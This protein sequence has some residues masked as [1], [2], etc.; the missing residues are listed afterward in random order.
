MSNRRAIA[1]IFL[2]GVVI[3]LV[4]ILLVSLI[5][6]LI[7]RNTTNSNNKTATAVVAKK[8][9][10]IGEIAANP[11]LF[12]DK[13]VIIDGSIISWATPHAFVIS[14][15]G[16]SILVITKQSYP[17]P[18]ETSGNNVLT[19]G[20]SAVVSVEGK[21]ER[22]DLAELENKWGVNLDDKVLYN[23]NNSLVIEADSI[24]QN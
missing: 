5:R 1:L 8:N 22:L 4:L 13:K 15:D 2:A 12:V 19:V 20:S 23:W 7:S 24:K 16:G 10:T 17:L 18:T 14:G 9:I 6:S 11:F 3:L 21:V